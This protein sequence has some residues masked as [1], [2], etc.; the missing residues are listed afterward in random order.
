MRK[1]APLTVERK[2]SKGGF[3][4]EQTPHPSSCPPL[5]ADRPRPFRC[6]SFSH[7]N[8]FAGFA[9]EPGPFAI[10]LKTTKE[11][12]IPLPWNHHPS[13]YRRWRNS[14]RQIFNGRK[15]N[16][17]HGILCAWETQSDGPTEGCS[18]RD[19][20]SVNGTQKQ[21]AFSAR[22]AIS[23]QR[24]FL[25]YLFCR[26]RK[27]MARGAAGMARR[28]PPRLRRIRNTLSEARHAVP[29]Q[30]AALVME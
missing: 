19:A 18:V 4:S 16:N 5:A 21:N 6:S 22:S 25:P 30:C 9:W 27:D 15:R 14:I 13:E 7:T 11:E 3:A 23:S 2:N 26:D 1:K 28:I 24:P 29:M 12:A 20:L 10:P 17:S 8:R